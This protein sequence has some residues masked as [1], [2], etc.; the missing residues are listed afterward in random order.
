MSPLTSPGHPASARLDLPSCPVAL[1][2]STDVFASHY[3][4]VPGQAVSTRSHHPGHPIQPVCLAPSIV[5]DTWYVLVTRCQ[6]N[7]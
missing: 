5:F 3:H 2:A 6:V 1:L 7:Q 4:S